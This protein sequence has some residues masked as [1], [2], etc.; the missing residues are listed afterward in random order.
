MSEVIVERGYYRGLNTTELKQRGSTIQYF[1][2][3]KTYFR[4]TEDPL[5][6]F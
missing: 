6:W 2:R 4:A 5:G 1:D 3:V